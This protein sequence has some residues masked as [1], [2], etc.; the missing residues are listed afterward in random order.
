MSTRNLF[1]HRCR[2]FARHKWD[3]DDL[4][5]R[6]LNSAALILVE[7]LEGVVA[8]LNVDVGLGGSEK[9]GG[10]DVRENGHSTDRF[11]GSK[12][13]G[14]VVFCIYRTPFAFEAAHSGVAV[15]ADQKEVAKV[16]GV[17]EI[18]DMAEMKDVE[19]AIGDDE[20]LAT[21]ELLS[22]C[23][24]VCVGNDLC[25]EVQARIDEKTDPLPRIRADRKSPLF[26]R[27]IAGTF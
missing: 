18:G 19:A 14:A 5:A 20:F 3:E 6:R 10:A 17:F 13:R 12:H 4:A 9:M 23:A 27:F 15:D 21:T 7:S 22:P 2:G 16:S 26:D 8:T 1:E 11:K 25:S 24:E